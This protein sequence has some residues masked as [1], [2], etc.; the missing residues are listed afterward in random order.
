[1]SNAL[2][3]SLPGMT[4]NIKKTPEW[5]TIIQRSVS[6]NELR[7][8]YTTAPVYNITLTFDVLRQGGSYSELDTLMGFF[9]AR[10]GSFDSFL[11]ADPSADSASA[12]SFGIGDGVEVDFQLQSTM[13]GYTEAVANIGVAPAIYANGVLQVSGYTV[14]SAGLVHFTSPPAS[15]AT[16]TWTGTF[17]MRCRFK[18][19]MTE[20]NNFMRQLWEARQVQL[21]GSFGTK[22]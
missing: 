17:Y 19:D 13:G 12:Q 11:L 10:R 4:W 1:M 22:V 6:L 16:L 15:G 18:E 20:F 21:V 9:L 14:S 2:F 3:P 5:N 8:S 7:G